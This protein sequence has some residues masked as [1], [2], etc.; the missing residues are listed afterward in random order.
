MDTLHFIN[1]ARYS[2]HNNA[3][4]AMCAMLS[5]V[6]SLLFTP[7]ASATMCAVLHFGMRCFPVFAACIAS[8][9]VKTLLVTVRLNAKNS[10]H[11]KLM[12]SQSDHAHG[13]CVLQNLWHAAP[14]VDHLSV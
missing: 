11:S 4:L 6:Y 8:H 12:Q 10:S 13:P 1:S 5:T 14:H 3:V 2:L 7:Q 9:G